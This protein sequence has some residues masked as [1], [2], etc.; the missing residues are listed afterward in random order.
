MSGIFGIGITGIQAAQTGMLVTQHNITNSGTAGY[1]RQS[2]IQ[3]SA[4]GVGSGIGFIG[5][6][7]QI[8]TVSRQ[9]NSFLTEQQRQSETQYSS[10]NTYFGNI[11]VIDDLLA[12]ANAGVSPA[13][14]DFFKGVQQVA[15]SPSSTE[16]RQ[17]MVSTAQSLVARLQGADQRISN[18][19]GQVNQQVSDTAELVNTYAKQIAALNEKITIAESSTS[20]PANDLLDQRDQLISEVNKLVEVQTVPVGK[21]GIEV[22]IGRG[23]LLVM[24]NRASTFSAVKSSQDPSRVVLALDTGTGNQELPEGFI[25]G[26][27]LGGL[28][29][30]R[31]GTLDNA[32]NSLGKIAA[33]LALS[34]NA[35]HAVGMDKNGRNQGDAGFVADFFQIGS[36][37]VIPSEPLVASFTPPRLSDP[38]S[39]GNYFTDLT[40]SDYQLKFDAGTFTLMRL[41]DSTVWTDTTLAGLNTQINDPTDARGAQG[42]TLTDDGS[43]FNNGDSFL[44]EPTREIAK[45]IA[46]NKSIVSDVNLIAAGSAMRTSV[47]LT[48]NGSMK[49]TLDRM[50]SGTPTL[51]Y[52][53]NVA[54][55]N[56][57]TS[58]ELTF[59]PAYNGQ[60]VNIIT[61]T[62]AFPTTYTIGGAT[63]IPYDTG[64]SYVLDGVMFSLSGTPKEG[65]S[66]SIDWNDGQSGSV[67]VADSS[68]IM[69]LGKLQ[70]Q[71]TMDGGAT[72]YQASYAQMVSNIGNKASEIEVTKDAQKALV[73]QATAARDSESGVNLDEEAA[74]LLKFQQLYQASARSISIGQKLFDE[75]LSIAGG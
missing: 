39:T 19:Y 51:T 36:P 58:P 13:L 48:N 45:D 43:G 34:F 18:L 50:L 69:L 73:D 28:M 42:I 12:D 30:F 64:A 32:I 41:S 20:Q 11:Q 10:L 49:V 29:S 47:G 2:M 9:Y 74:A 24:G 63:P 7:V 60:T 62:G 4:P 16:A 14:Q 54:I 70:T 71:N 15:A 40:G 3:T 38:Q 46:V 6:G 25:T 21:N 23:Q 37:K 68:N 56:V 52:P 67:G 17:S 53:V 27:S 72:S 5:N 75:L 59:D 44:I 57:A 8:T 33:S 31:S 1:N 22:F 65:D 26:G 55:T 35:Q 61:S 66:F